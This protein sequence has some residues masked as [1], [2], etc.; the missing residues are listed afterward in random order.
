MSAEPGERPVMSDEAR[1][2]VADARSRLAGADPLHLRRTVAPIP[3]D[4]HAFGDHDQCGPDCPERVGEP[5]PGV[6]G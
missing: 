4:A 6:V 5:A 1:R 3:A 2:L